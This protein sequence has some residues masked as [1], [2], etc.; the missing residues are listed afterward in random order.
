MCA[1]RF[2]FVLVVVRFGAGCPCM[3]LVP[4]QME[5]SWLPPSVKPQK[6]EVM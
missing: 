5:W 4:M 6:R 3:E 2:R 1:L